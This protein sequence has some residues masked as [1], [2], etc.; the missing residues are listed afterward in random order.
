[1]NGLLF[2]PYSYNSIEP[3]CDEI[4]QYFISFDQACLPHF[5]KVNVQ[6]MF[7][8]DFYPESQLNT[9]KPFTNQLNPS[10][11]RHANRF[12]AKH[13]MVIWSRNL[14]I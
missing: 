1:M 13:D 12:F 3:D 6:P 11:L 9:P 10:W 8:A 2:D 4:I 7:L 14:R 5:N